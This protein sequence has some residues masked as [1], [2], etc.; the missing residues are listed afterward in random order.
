MNKNEQAILRIIA[1][2][3]AGMEVFA[4][5]VDAGED[6]RV[7][8]P[9]DSLRIQQI[10]AS[11]QDLGLVETYLGDYGDLIVC[12]TAAGLRSSDCHEKKAM[13]IDT[14]LF[15]ARRE[16][17]E[18]FTA[19]QRAKP[20]SLEREQARGELS[21]CRERVSRIRC[22]I[23][24]RTE[25]PTTTRL[26]DLRVGDTIWWKGEPK[27]ITRLGGLDGWRTIFWVEDGKEVETMNLTAGHRFY[28]YQPDTTN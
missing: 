13:D 17:S 16:W 5:E 22:A 6:G 26:D 14:E 10:L 4:V 20:G 21:E 1:Q 9:T 23:A 27:T 19:V 18:A 11:L 15:D 3:P 25:H 2:K 12:P 8:G 28:A 7:T 24:N